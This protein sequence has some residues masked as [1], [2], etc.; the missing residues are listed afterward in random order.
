MPGSPPDNFLDFDALLAKVNNQADAVSKFLWNAFSKATQQV[1]SDVLATQA[2]KKAALINE[3]NGIFTA[4][5]IYDAQLFAGVTLSS[6]TLALL[7]QKPSG[8]NLV[9]LNELLLQDAYPQ[10]LG[11]TPLSGKYNYVKISGRLSCAGIMSDTEQTALKSLA[12]ITPNFETAINQL[13]SAPGIF[14]STH[15]SDIF[16]DLPEANAILL[17]HPEQNDPA[18]LEEKLLYVYDHFIPILKSKL[19]R[20]AITHH[21]AALIGLSE[22]S[23][24]LVIADKVESLIASLSTVGFSGSYFNDSKWQNFLLSKTDSTIDFSWGQKAPNAS[25]QDADDFSVRWETY[26]AAPASDD[27][28]LV[29]DVDGA[30][31]GFTLFLDDT[32]ILEKNSAASSWSVAT[33]LNAARLHS[34]RLDYAEHALDAGVRLQ[35]KRAT[36]ALEVI[37]ASAAYPKTVLDAFVS[38]V[39][40][41]HRAAKFI[42]GFEL[43]EVELDYLIGHKADFGNINFEALN[44]ERLGTHQRLHDVAKCRASNSGIAHRCFRSLPTYSNQPLA[45]VGRPQNKCSHLATAW[46]EPNLQFL[47]AHF[48]LS[49]ADFRNEIALKRILQ[50]MNIFARTGLSADT[51]AEWGCGR[52][53]LQR[54]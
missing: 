8:P 38:Q 33:S 22:Q 47:M 39:D 34:L 40:I 2:Q 11:K 35:W 23:S 44:V 28:T 13:Y 45:F 29:V 17:N 32:Q 42:G 10:E 52:N 24:A 27:Y 16:T 41:Y 36:T 21:I 30:D 1:L 50:V 25:I 48:S 3:L 6:E 26:L 46:D 20:D 7:S 53:G 49:R 4:G 37:P 19:R 14:L 43:T 54:S 18:T 9:R 5:P 31:E 51:I 15:F 12:N